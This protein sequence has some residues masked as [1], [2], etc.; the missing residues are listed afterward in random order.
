MVTSLSWP[1]NHA[2]PRCL[3]MADDV[4]QRLLEN[5]VQGRFDVWR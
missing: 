5:P 4:G 3:G 2:D 1:Q